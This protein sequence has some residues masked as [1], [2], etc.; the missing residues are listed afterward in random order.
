MRRFVRFHAFY[1]CYLS[2]RRH[3]LYAFA[4]A[5]CPGAS[6][7]SAVGLPALAIL[8]AYSSPG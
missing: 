1:P 4:G 5:C 8:A 2:E 7:G 3:P 6:A